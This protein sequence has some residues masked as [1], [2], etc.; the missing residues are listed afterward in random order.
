MT[1]NADTDSQSIA[2]IIT[3]ISV[4]S[5][6]SVITLAAS[7]SNNIHGVSS[8]GSSSKSNLGEII[9]SVIGDVGGLAII[10]AVLFFCLEEAEEEDGAR[11]SV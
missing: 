2:T 7:S 8:S 4:L 10:L 6:G 3:T 9:S 5:A 11:G 1:T